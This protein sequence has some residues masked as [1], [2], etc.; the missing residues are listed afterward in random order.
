MVL[1]RIL[2]CRWMAYS[3]KP[4]SRLELENPHFKEMLAGY[5]R[6]PVADVPIVSRK[7]IEKWYAPLSFALDPIPPPCFPPHPKTLSP[8]P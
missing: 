4:R 5:A 1:N 7:G 2:F 6:V 8:Q 3:G